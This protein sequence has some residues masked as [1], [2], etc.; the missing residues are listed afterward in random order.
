MAVRA[1]IF[2]NIPKFLEELDRQ[3]GSIQP[4]TAKMSLAAIS[5]QPSPDQNTHQA[6]QYIAQ[7][8][9]ALAQSVFAPVPMQPAQAGLEYSAA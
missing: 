4:K 1:D 5:Q 3:L 9:L 7:A 2:V 8:T 6:T